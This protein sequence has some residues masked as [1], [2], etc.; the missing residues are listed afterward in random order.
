[1]K[2]RNILPEFKIAGQPDPKDAADY[3]EKMKTLQQL[4]NNPRM[5]D[6]ETQATIAKRKEELRKWAEKNLPKEEI[7]DIDE[8]GIMY[9]AGVKKYGKEGMRKIQSA[10]GKGASHQEIG[11][12]KDKYVKDDADID[13]QMKVDI[14]QFLNT[15]VAGIERQIEMQPAFTQ[16][17]IDNKEFTLKLIDFV[18]KKLDDKQKGD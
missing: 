8:S 15:K 4:Q 1:M 2:I 11:K 3:K 6:P 14:L 13:Q 10:A 16:E 12:I 7:L 17:D 18:Q 9:R 5:R